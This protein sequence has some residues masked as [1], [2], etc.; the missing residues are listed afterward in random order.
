MSMFFAFAMPGP[1]ELMIV[2][3]IV[4]LLFGGSKLPSLM[5]NLGRAKGEFTKGMNENVED[6][7]ESRENV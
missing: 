6:E 2:M 5:R 4:L 3:C 7:V 1:A